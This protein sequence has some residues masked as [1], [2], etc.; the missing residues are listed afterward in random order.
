MNFIQSQNRN[1]IEFSS[2]ED[3]IDLQNPVRVVDEFVELMELD[4]LG[5][6]VNTI[7]SEGRPGFN[8][9]VFLKLYLYGY[10]NGIRSIKTQ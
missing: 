5:F 1:Q 8:S 3:A 2:L 9:K 10:L 7:K 4:K 6:E